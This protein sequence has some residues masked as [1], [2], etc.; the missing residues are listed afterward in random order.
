MNTVLLPSVLIF[1]AAGSSNA[2]FLIKQLWGLMKKNSRKRKEREQK[3]QVCYRTD[4][5]VCCQQM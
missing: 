5:S 4:D 3:D 2:L 1:K